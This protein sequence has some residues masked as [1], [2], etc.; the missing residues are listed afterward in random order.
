MVPGLSDS[1]LP[2]W[3]FQLF[4]IPHDTARCGS[5]R[6]SSTTCRNGVGTT[7]DTKSTKREEDVAAPANGPHV[8][9]CAYRNGR[10]KRNFKTHAP[11]YCARRRFSRPA[12]PRSAAPLR[13][14]PSGPRHLPPG[15]HFGLRFLDFR[16]RLIP[17]RTQGQAE[18]QGVV[19]ARRDDPETVRGPA[20]H[21]EAVPAAA[22]VDPVRAR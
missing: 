7:K 1:P 11:G 19:P 12:A 16:L 6:P 22:P 20:V 13:H 3:S 18:A 2:S 10:S 14:L 4:A 9:A 21:G 15:L 8:F 17:G 5:Q